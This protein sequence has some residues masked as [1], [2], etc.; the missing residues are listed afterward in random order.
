MHELLEE[1]DADL[2]SGDPLAFPGYADQVAALGAESVVTGRTAHVVVVESCFDVLG[3]SMGVVAGEK[4]VRA[5]ARATELRLPAVCIIRSGGARMQ[6]G[7]VSLLQL[8]RTTDAL[9]AHG[10]AGLLSVALLRSPTT[11][12]VF[13]SYGS[14]CDVRAAEPGAI[15][16]FAGPRVV[17]QTT[18]ELVGE[19]SHTAEAAHRHGLVD[20]VVDRSASARWIDGAL[21]LVA[22]PLEVSRV[23]VPAVEEVVPA[24]AWGEVVRA[25]RP[26]RPTGIEVAGAI[27]TSWTELAGGDPTVRAGLAS[28]DGDRVIVV[29]TDR[30]HRDG[31]PT[32]LGFRLVQR[33]VAL[34]DR[35]GLPFVS[36]VDM[37][38][39][40]PSSQSENDGV[41]REIARTLAAMAVLR[42]PS[43]SVCVGEGGSG[44][45][46]AMAWADRLLIQT[47][48][49]FSVIGP[50]GAAAII[51]RDASRAPEM[52]ARL[53][54]TSADLAAIGIVDGLVGES[55]DDVRAAVVDALASAQP[56]DRARRADAVSAAWLRS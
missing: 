8:G 36:L 52:A 23:P 30:R 19:R 37:P 34:A 1:W 22:T 13:A 12:G 4:V 38:G 29:A 6:E 21:G 15:I 26:S 28:L 31:R 20:A 39:A 27:T 2:R 3:G 24:G 56:G 32:P 41:A 35:L 5:L 53:R 14:M 46:L 40:D 18:G 16:G 33:A 43:V 50:E 9:R 48:A 44:G 54:L 47:H 7:M 49:V 45:A 17:E 55:A 42:S 51:E 10:A 25:R 11:G